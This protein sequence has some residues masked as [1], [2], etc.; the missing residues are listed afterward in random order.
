VS[1]L[2]YNDEGYERFIKGDFISILPSHHTHGMQGMDSRNGPIM[3]AKRNLKEILSQQWSATNKMTK[4]DLIYC[5]KLAYFGGEYEIIKGKEKEVVRG[6][7]R[8]LLYRTLDRVGWYTDDRTGRLMYDPMSRIDPRKFKP[9][10]RY[11]GGH[12]LG[13][14]EPEPDMVIG[15]GRIPY[16]TL[17]SARAT[18]AQVIA[19]EAL[20]R[21]LP[22]VVPASDPAKKKPRR[23]QYKDGCIMRP[24]DCAEAERKRQAEDAELAAKRQIAS[25]KKAEGDS[26]ARVAVSSI[27]A[28][29]VHT[30]EETVKTLGSAQLSNVLRVMGLPFSGNIA[31]KQ[32]RIVAGMPGFR[33]TIA[34]TEGGLGNFL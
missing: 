20:T 22:A 30:P 28:Q 17:E 15:G 24:S 31:P 13:P 21:T 16:Y 6:V 3:T 12:N 27:M 23:G 7:D 9:A 25:K 8:D 14:T 34:A 32:A 4:N 11:A 1:E 5:L 19:G 33:K 18:Q 10:A 2:Y 26:A 29:L